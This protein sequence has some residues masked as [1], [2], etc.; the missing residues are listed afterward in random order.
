L[1]GERRLTGETV[2]VQE[3]LEALWAT[4]QSGGPRYEPLWRIEDRSEVIEALHGVR[5]NGPGGCVPW[6]L[7]QHRDLVA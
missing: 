3:V 5:L 2:D 1:E 7:M 4:P 6:P